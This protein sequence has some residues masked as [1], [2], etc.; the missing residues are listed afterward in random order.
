[1]VELKPCDDVNDLNQLQVKQKEVLRERKFFFVLDDVWNNNYGLWNVLRCAF[2]SGAQGS[3][4]IVTTRHHEVAS[5]VTTVQPFKLETLSYED[6]WQL[7]V[8]HAF[9]HVPVG[10]NQKFEMIGRKIVE[11]CKGLPLVVKSRRSWK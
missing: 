9:V 2:E 11:R 1:M 4:I 7:V 6:Y 3:K 8:K 10:A 5:M